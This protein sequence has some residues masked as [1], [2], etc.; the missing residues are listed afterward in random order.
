MRLIETGIQTIHVLVDWLHLALENDTVREELLLCLRRID[1]FVALCGSLTRHTNARQVR[2]FGR[3][4]S[5]L[6]SVWKV[7]STLHCGELLA[8]LLASAVDAKGACIKK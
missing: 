5:D 4:I 3:S 7:R 2:H 1:Y 6:R 8:R